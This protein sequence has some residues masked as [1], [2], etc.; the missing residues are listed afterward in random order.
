[1]S[2]NKAKGRETHV[3]FAPVIQG[4]DF[5]SGVGTQ[6]EAHQTE[7]AGKHHGSNHPSTAGGKRVDCQSVP[8]Q[9]YEPCAYLHCIQFSVHSLSCL[10]NL[11]CQ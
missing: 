6:D 7:D 11:V 4:V 9:V 8:V 2:P 3:G 5:R 10:H 1:V